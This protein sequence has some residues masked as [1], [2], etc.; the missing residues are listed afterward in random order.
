M[1]RDL[2]LEIGVEELPSAYMT[3]ALADLQTLAEKKLTEARLG[4]D[5]LQILGTPRR[6]TIIAEGM[7]EMQGDANIENRGPKKTSAFDVDGKPSKAGL[8][9][10][11]GQGLEFDQLEIREQGGIEY[12]FAV[13]REA[14]R[15]AA[16]VLPE[17]LPD[18]INS[19]VFP[20]SMRWGAYTTRFARPIRWL[21]ALFGQDIVRF[22]IE[23]I[24]SSN[25]TYGHRFLS[26]GSLE[27]GGLA[28]Y[29]QKLRDNF[30][31]LDQE[32]RQAMVWQQVQD[33]AARAGG[34]AMQNED[35]LEE[36]TYLVEYP[37][38]FFGSFSSSYLEVPPEVLT[39]SMI[40][41]QRYFP[42]YSDSGDLLPGFIGVKNGRDYSMDLVIAGNE[43]VIKAR[44]ED[45]LF[46][47]RED[48]KKTLESMVPGFENVMFHERLGTLMDKVNRL[49]QISV[50]LGTV[51]GLSS[52][53][54]LQRAALLAKADL[55]SAM[56]Y[57]FPELQGI[58]GRYYALQS[59]E[60]TEVAQAILEHYLPRFAGDSLPASAAGIVLCL[61]EKLHNLV[62]CF[63][64]GIKPTGSQDPYALRR[65]ALGL[66]NIILENK[67]HID[68]R[69][70]LLETYACFSGVKLKFD[71]DTTASELME[72][73][74]QRMRGI[75]QERGISYDVIDAVFAVPS[76][77][78]TE[79]ADRITCVD[80]FKN[81]AY[82]DDFMVVYNRANNL[83]RKW[84]NDEV[85]QSVLVDESEK[86]L[87]A[88]MHHL[89]PRVRDMIARRDYEGALRA[90][91]GLRSSVDD[92]F[93]AVMIMVD[94]ERLKASRLGLLKSIAN[95][96]QLVADFSKLVI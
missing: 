10:A 74:L 53:D 80:E 91:A 94:D 41:H 1:K 88:T 3:R 64:I 82:R 24:E 38:A 36:V 84:E 61:S 77:D 45:A 71:A 63:A 4:Y 48:G 54:K 67:L 12:L 19:L 95:Y 8:G 9:F 20:K 6:L 11:R 59:G 16:E 14:G 57:E 58:M 47:W 78:L 15:P 49:G 86:N 75:L 5:R 81:A 51:T 37:T 52:S 70:I 40:E 90:L 7:T 13:K 85:D 46:F 21:L 93:E 69:K 25:L 55:L 87:Y 66:V 31:I 39:T 96:C 30:V 68:L 23:N 83:S 17:V 65:Q 43:R 56:V 27:V 72:F 79:V 62:G 22:A 50:N 29:K 92:F 42:V 76:S 18:I 34:H 89:A 32:E 60:D 73:I 35:L 28:E 33:V 2:I 44:L 26:S